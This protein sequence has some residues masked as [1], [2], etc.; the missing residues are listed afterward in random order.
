MKIKPNSNL[1]SIK[2]Y[3]SQEQWQAILKCINQ[4]DSPYNNPS[5]FIRA[6]INFKLTMIKKDQD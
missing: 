5:Q 2:L 6:A 4:P 3:L 1:R